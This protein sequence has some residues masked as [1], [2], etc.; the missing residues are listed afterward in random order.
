[1]KILG[2]T[3]GVGAGKST[4]LAYLQKQYGARVILADEAGHMVQEPGKPCYE[5]IVEQFG[6]E[7]LEKTEPGSRI[8]RQK[9]GAIVYANPEKLEILNQIVHPAVKT[10]ILSE[11]E[12]ERQKGEV[13]FVTIEAALLLEDHYEQ[14]CDEIWYVY[15]EEAVRAERLAAGRGYSA[16]KTESIMKNQMKDAEFRSRC[17]FVIDN[18]SDFMENTYK[19]IDKGLVE[20]GFL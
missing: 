19:Q 18:S 5:K 17:D 2:I 11:I 3:G 14:F 7:I 12:K 13:P 8:D 20:H 1:M 16:K 10:H 15:A 4:I 9:L 6:E